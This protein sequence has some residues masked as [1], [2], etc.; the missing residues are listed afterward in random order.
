MGAVLGLMGEGALLAGLQR[1]LSLTM[2]SVLLVGALLTWRRPFA[3]VFPRITELVRTRLG[4]V[5]QFPSPF[6]TLSI[7]FLNGLLP[8]GLVY[9]ALAAS[10]TAGSFLG[11]ILYMVAFGAGTFPMMLAAALGG[12]RLQ[13]ILRAR[14]QHLI[15]LAV[16]LVGALL[17]LR[18]LALGIPYLS[19]SG[20]GASCH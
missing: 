9:V 12:T 7:G 10:A 8:C 13:F 16:A 2:G 4:R 17:V 18:G 6:Q 15:P 3:L 19:P 11:S 5:M 14:G 20:D 1:W